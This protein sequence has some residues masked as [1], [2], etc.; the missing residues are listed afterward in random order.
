MHNQSSRGP[1]ALTLAL[2]LAAAIAVPAHAQQLKLWEISSTNE[3][4]NRNWENVIAQFEAE[5]PGV[6]VVMET[7]DNEA[8][9]QGLAVALTSTS[10]P[11]IFF[12][13]GSEDSA[14]LA[15]NGL[16]ADVTDMG[17]GRWLDKINAG[18]LAP[19][20]VAGRA[21]GVPSHSIAKYMYYNTAFYEDNGLT[22]PTT[23]DEM[24]AMCKTVREIDPEVAFTSLGNR[25][26][27]KGIHYVSML[28]AEYVGVDAMLADMRLQ[29]PDDTLFTDPGY[30]KALAMLR[31]MEVEG[32]F[33]QGVNVTTAD[34]SRTIFASGLTTSIY[35]GTWCPGTFDSEGLEGG[36]SMA[37]FPAVS[38]APEEN[39]GYIL[40]LT[41]GFQIS[42]Q[43]QHKELAADFID[44]I[45]SDAVQ[46][47]RLVLAGRI[48]VNGAGVGA[49][50]DE[51]HPAIQHVVADLPNYKGFAPILDVDLDG[52]I[53]EVYKRGIQDVIDGRVTPEELMAKVRAEAL[54]VKAE[55]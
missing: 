20:S 22:F 46:A 3:G 27:W 6:E 31:T 48:P 2:G 1:R 37:P 51:V 7:F 35:C 43:S 41:E 54:A 8:F 33:Q 34:M 55:R 44:L 11:D 29:N 28:T 50:S 40:G 21:Y 12:N 30:V 17:E 13:W 26:Q 9:K 19:F 23:T 16:A 42:A 10:G 36:Y 45:L 49:V 24:L 25:D 14:V 15:R 18:M 52:R 47:E 5:H 53:V 39:H 38:D 32:C 4:V